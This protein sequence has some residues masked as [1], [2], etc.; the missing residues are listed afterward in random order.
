MN[1][2]CLTANAQ[3]ISTSH[4]TSQNTNYTSTPQDVIYFYKQAGDIVLSANSIDNGGNNTFTWS[5]YDA[6]TGNWN[7]FQSQIGVGQ[8]SNISEGGYQV[9]V[10]NGSTTQT[11][12]CWVLVPGFENT[13]LNKAETDTLYSNCREVKLEVSNYLPKPLSYY[14]PANNL[15][16]AV[17]YTYSFVW[18]A[19]EV[20][21]KI[22]NTPTYRLSAPYDN[23]SYKTGITEL[24]SNQTIESEPF[25]LTAI[26]VLADFEIVPTTD[27]SNDFHT[28]QEESSR[29]EITTDASSESANPSKGNIKYYDWKFDTYLDPKTV[30]NSSWSFTGTGTHTVGLKVYNDYC[31]DTS[32]VKTVTLTDMEL[33][34]PNY[35]NPDADDEGVRKF[36][37]TYHSIKSFDIVIVNRWGRPVYKSKDIEEGWDGRIGG[38]K[39]APGVYYYDI[40]AKGYN[41]GESMHK[42]GFLHLMYDH[43]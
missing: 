20:E 8:I 9:V 13:E 12:R 28:N 3:I 21:A 14:N 43:K 19:N 31:N 5:Q 23:T 37:V 15:A 25:Q 27:D 38:Q 10:S 29:L 22:T 18:Y 2:L 4:I 24:L 40:V 41:K 11:Y 26:A 17:N 16:I 42:K 1:M 6:Q 32:E 35:F 33:K 34:I 36:K 7:F 30:P 39:A